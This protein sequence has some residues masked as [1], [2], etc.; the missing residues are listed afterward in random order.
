M[1]FTNIMQGVSILTNFGTSSVYILWLYVSSS[2]IPYLSLLLA[3]FQLPFTNISPFFYFHSSHIPWRSTLI[4]RLYYFHNFPYHACSFSKMWLALLPFYVRKPVMFLLILS[5][6]NPLWSSF[7]FTVSD[8][9]GPYF[10][11]TEICNEKRDMQRQQKIIP[12][13]SLDS[14]Q[15]EK[16][17]IISERTLDWIT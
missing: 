4:S 12:E 2:L 8:P 11:I 3:I 1:C 15:Q 7:F 13:Q 6:F 14:L 10:F 9:P 5:Y 17:N 16:Q